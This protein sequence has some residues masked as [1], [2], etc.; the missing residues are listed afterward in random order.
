MQFYIRSFYNKDNF[1]IFGEM[2]QKNPENREMSFIF[3]Q[4]CFHVD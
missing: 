1:Q 2:V 4:L 3:G